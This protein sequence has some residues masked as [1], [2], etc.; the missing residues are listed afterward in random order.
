MHL[1]PAVDIRTARIAERHYGYVTRTQAYRAGH[2]RSSLASR[3]QRGRLE[4]VNVRLFRVPGAPRT[5]Q[6]DVYAATAAAPTGFA[7]AMTAGALFGACAPPLVPH[8]VVPRGGRP[9][10]VT[11]IVH[12]S[13][14]DPAD[15]TTFGVI[16]VTRPAR[17]PVD[18]SSLLRRDA[19]DELVD[20]LLTLGLTDR[21]E[22]LA[23]IE[24]SARGP[25]RKGIPDL[26]ASLDV[27]QPGIEHDSVAEARMFRLV[28]G[29]GHP[30]PIPLYVIRDASGNPLCEVD[31]AW[32]DRKVALEYDSVRWHHP[33]RWSKD[34]GRAIAVTALG[35]EFVPV[36]KS[37]LAP[38]GQNRLRADLERLLLVPTSPARADEEVTGH[39]RD[40][41]HPADLRQ[42]RRSG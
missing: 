41:R 17:I 3:T 31:A 27:W 40:L 32:P 1:D 12:Q 11:A 8:L 42:L 36:D 13:R 35:W 4:Q 19:L 10:G 26:L 33:R 37:D 30:M 7:V 22:V 14:V 25:G 6:G 20:G 29:W 34:E 24:R 21:D 39:D 23:S 2:T 28:V 16:P 15:V 9:R 38:G 18:C 5:W